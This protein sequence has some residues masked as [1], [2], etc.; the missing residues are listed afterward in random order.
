MEHVISR[1]TLLLSGAS[2]AALLVGCAT[3][4]GAL[5]A[6]VIAGFGAIAK[7]AGLVLPQLQATG[8][9][10]GALN[11]VTTI[12]GELQAAAAAITG[13][14][15]LGAGQSTLTRVEGYVNALAP[16]VLPFVALIPGGAVIS[17]LVAALPELEIAINFASSLLS[18][19][20]RQVAA[21]VPAS[22]A[23]GRV[24]L[25]PLERLIQ[26]AGA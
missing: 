16:L 23:P 5:P 13:A 26:L 21:A 3:T 9:A 25:T 15:S 18:A 20:A 11:T 19:Q 7:T 1:R 10:G 12:L 14:S 6:T 24:G 4:S 8:L 22:A 17:L 2:S